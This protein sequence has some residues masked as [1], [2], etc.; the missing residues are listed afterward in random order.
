MAEGGDPEHFCSYDTQHQ[1]DCEYFQGG[2]QVEPDFIPAD[3]FT[4]D[5]ETSQPIQPAPTTQTSTDSDFIPADQFTS[6]ETSAPTQLSDQDKL[7]Q[8]FPSATPYGGYTP[9]EMQGISKGAKAV[10]PI[11][12]AL[13]A[14]PA[15][16]AAAGIAQA[17]LAEALPGISG[18]L[19]TGRAATVGANI[20]KNILATNIYQAGD[21]VAKV[22][23]GQGDPRDGAGAVAARHGLASLLGLVTGGIGSAG[24][25]GANYVVQKAEQK[26]GGQIANF[27]SGFGSRMQNSAEDLVPAAFTDSTGQTVLSEI[28]EEGL[29]A[30]NAGH[31]FSTYYNKGQAAADKLMTRGVDWAK[32]SVAKAGTYLGAQAG[33]IPGV[34]IGDAIAALVSK[35]LQRL[36]PSMAQKVI[37]P[38]TM[39]IL[40]SDNTQG[41]LDAL[42][43]ASAVNQGYN[44]VADTAKA[45]VYGATLPAISKYGDKSDREALDQHI[46]EGGQDVQLQK[47]AQQSTPQFAEGGQVETEPTPL[48]ETTGTVIH[49]PEQAAL[50]AATK[51]RASN[52]LQTLKPHNNPPELAFDDKPDI[53]D[54]Q[55]TYDKALDIANQPLGILH[56][57][58]NGTIEPEHVQHF[59][60]M[61]PEVDNLL[62]KELTKNILKS[63]LDGQKPSYQVRQGLSLLMGTSLSGEFMP[64]SIQAT[65][66]VFQ[67]QQPQQPQ[68]QPPKRQSH[69]KSALSKLGQ[70]ALTPEQ[71]R[72]TREQRQD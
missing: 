36:A 14:G 32:K 64:E 18:I 17:G 7:R 1:S 34:V 61:Y 55:R 49:Y 3:Q 4:S 28:P 46:T 19:G 71:A 47:E 54:K 6:D 44:M 66:A 16:G 10:A 65:Q 60:T 62:Q 21:D 20:V 35:A 39:K 15:V 29:E 56:E 37:A 48:T 38:A 42:N 33:G 45:L 51:L 63:Q 52:Y 13:A 40:A 31:N 50:L 69:S 27:M 72:Q 9:E 11:G 43:H 59:K 53:R 41:L 70:S 58:K 30:G 12:V 5:V 22:I 67:A 25:G 24:K 68:G 8:T 26:V 23:A 57:I 2:G